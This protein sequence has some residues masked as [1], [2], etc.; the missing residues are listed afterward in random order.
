MTERE[1]VDHPAHYGGENNVY[2]CIKVIEA[3]D[4]G[5]HEGNVV[6]YLSRWRE[7]GGIK[8]L[9]KA[10]WYLNRFIKQQEALCRTDP[11]I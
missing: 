2:E 3:W 6:K 5:F 7:K 8:D 1:A 10:A 9:Y 11:S 4:L